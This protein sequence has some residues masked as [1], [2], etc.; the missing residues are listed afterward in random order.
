MRARE[1]YR[2]SKR[3]EARARKLVW[4]TLDQIKDATGSIRIKYPFERLGKI[5]K[6]KADGE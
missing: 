1:T 3:N 6:D 4:R 2:G 5:I